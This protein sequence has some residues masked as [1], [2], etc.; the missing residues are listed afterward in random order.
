MITDPIANMLTSIRNAQAARKPFVRVPYSRLK[1][2]IAEV[3]RT[4]GYIGPVSPASEDSRKLLEVT[5]LYEASGQPRIRGLQRISKP[6]RR[7]YVRR[8]EIPRI[9]S[10]LGVAVLSTS[11]GLLADAEARK[12]GLGGEVICTVW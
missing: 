7:W 5:L 4:A 11:K 6:G 8:Q 10:G 9:L 3:L 2:E 12:R 1:H